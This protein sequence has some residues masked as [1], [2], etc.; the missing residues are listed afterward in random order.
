[1]T[2]A[3]HDFQQRTRQIFDGVEYAPKPVLV[4]SDAEILALDG[5]D[6][7]SLVPMLGLGEPVSDQQRALATE[8]AAQRLFETG[9]TETGTPLGGP[10]SADEEPTAR[11]VLRLRRQ[12]LSALLIDQNSGLG[13]QFTAVYVRAD[14]RA[15]VE[16]TTH[17]GRHQF[18]AMKRAAA[19]DA[20]A[21]LLNPLPD[22]ADDDGKG[23]VYPVATW[24]QDA[25]TLLGQA[26]IAASVIS[27]R[28]NKTMDRRAED[29]FALYNFDDRSE[30]LYAESPERVRI[31]PISRRTLRERLEEITSPLDA[32][33]AD[34]E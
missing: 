15:L 14:R 33:G 24:Q 32:Q 12:W 11:T 30:I 21:G 18:T 22:V 25:Q 27:L 7:A 4:I 3:E 9:R 34:H 1:M 16:V 10:D 13:R 20:A 26:K 2:D 29:R 23:R 31:A 19:L 17:D 6:K 28:H 8:E 5:P